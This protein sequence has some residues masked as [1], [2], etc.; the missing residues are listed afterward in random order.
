MFSF[1]LVDP[2][3]TIALCSV[4]LI[5]LIAENAVVI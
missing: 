3:I 2:V 4:V 5:L 1:L